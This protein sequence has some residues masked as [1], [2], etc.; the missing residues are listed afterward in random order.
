MFLFFCTY[1]YVYVSLCIVICTHS[2]NSAHIF[3]VYNSVICTVIQ[4]FI[5]II[6]ISM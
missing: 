3:I 4:Y 5:L 1:V 6:I 2:F